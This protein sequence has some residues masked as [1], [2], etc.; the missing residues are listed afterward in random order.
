MATEIERKFLVDEAAWREYV[1]GVTPVTIVQGYLHADRNHSVRVRIDDSGARIAIKG[2]TRGIS[3]TEFEYEIPQSDARELLEFCLGHLIE[4][5]RFVIDHDG[6]SWEIDCFAGD[7]AGLVVA[8][9]E[10]ED[11]DQQVS[12]PDWVG[13]EISDRPEYYNANLSQYPYRDW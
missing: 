6:V 9:V 1:S 3:R 5:Q 2:P 8:E 12:L 13:R 7:N 10:L 11:P 4:K